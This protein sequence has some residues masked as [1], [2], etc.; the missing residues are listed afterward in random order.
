MFWRLLLKQAV[1]HATVEQVLD[2]AAR[3]NLIIGDRNG[4]RMATTREVLKEER[5]VIDYAKA[6]Q[7]T[8]RPLVGKGWK[9]KR[10]KLN[11]GQRNAV[12]HIIESRDRMILVSGA[13]GVGKTT[14]MQEAV[15]AIESSGKR[16]FPFA[17]SADASR[18]TLRSDGFN[19][20]ETVAT[21]L[22]NDKLQQQIAGQVIWVDEAGRLSV[23]AMT[24]IFALADRLE[25]SRAVFR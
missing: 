3:S 17:P 10:E 24:E 9:I 13:A 5:R 6:S 7:G 25:C 12:R 11:D 15:E 18:G 22:T 4:R 14:L 20:A 8:C 21:L 1:G 2:R 16:V 19:D 23:K